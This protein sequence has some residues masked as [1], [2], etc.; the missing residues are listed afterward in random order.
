MADRIKGLKIVLG[1]DTTELTQAI[2]NVNT[3]IK[4]TQANLRDINRALKFDPKNTE[5]LKD[6]QDELTRA[7]QDTK[8]KIAEEEKALAALKDAGISETSQEFRDLKT[9]IDIDKSSLQGFEGQMKSF[10]SVSS[11]VMQAVGGEIKAV[12]AKMKDIGG[13]I[14]DVGTNLTTKVTVPIVAA[15][16]AMVT[17]YAE[18]DK[19]MTLANKTM[20]NTAEEAKLLNDAMEEAAANSTFGMNDAAEASLNF[21]RAGLK[22]EQAAAALAPTM[23]LAAGEAG[24]LNV[25]SAGLVGT[26]NG[27]GDSFE[28]TT[29]YADVFA[30][31]CNNSALDVNTLAD[32]MGVAAP[33]FKTAGK[34]VEDAALMLGVMANANIDANTAANSLKTG[35]ARLA[36]PTKQAREAMEKYGISMSDIWNEN[37]SMK[38][39]TVIQKNLHE[40]FAQLS[41][42]EQMAAAGAIFGKNQMSSWLAV[43]NTAPEEVDRLSESIA[44]SKGTTEE[45]AE[46]LMGG[47]GGS[48]EKLKSSLD[49]LMT[50]LGQIIAEY[51]TP[52]IENVQGVVDA[53]MALDD[54]QKQHIVQIA[55]LVAAVGPVL[56]IVGKLVVGIGSVITAVGTITSAIGAVI[57]IISGAASLITS[58]VIP[59]IAAINAPILLIVGSIGLITAAIVTCIKH[60]DE[61]K[62]KTE[63]VVAAMSAKWDEFKNSVNDKWNE[64]KAKTAEVTQSVSQKWTQTRDSVSR[65]TS[66]IANGAIQQF[67]SM[68][69]AVS[70][71]IEGLKANLISTF[72]NARYGIS[73]VIGNIRSTII[74]GFGSAVDY[75]TS[76]PGQ[77]VE[78]GADIIGG[79]VEGIWDAFGS[80]VDAVSEIASTI[81]DYIGFSEPDKG[82]LSRFHTFMPDMM[83]LMTQGIKAGIPKLENAMGELSHSMVPALPQSMIAPMGTESSST[84]NNTSNSVSINV[85]GAQG[86]DV[87]EL[88]RV[89]ESKITDN[90]VR[91]GVAFG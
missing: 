88:A 74:S 85:Y 10:G 67:S 80:L 57:P 49:V 7:I 14:A 5:L 29:H 28:N 4:N 45:M 31:A 58:V 11:Q 77:A 48:I 17:K 43:I 63:E 32:S 38:D 51:L 15:G 36:E 13:K 50:S 25:V 19:T 16:T 9:Q 60:W 44:N 71:Q 21:A 70:N 12:G 20:N 69:N 46:A 2:Y 86:Q 78:W 73:S 18:V 52:V 23:N 34:N 79:V 55:G 3:A 27:F 41:E 24:D 75:I 89:I 56:L 62:A 53:F 54:E 65:A 72:E 8:T 1:A 35:M 82:E 76:L 59:A 87:D 64:L 39:M 90:V 91:R 47:F 37:G 42:Q 84:T 81:A 68:R 30:A 61:I 26:I 33:I 66:N 83:Q 40:S 6:K 22:A